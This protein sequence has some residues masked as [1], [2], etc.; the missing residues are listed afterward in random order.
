MLRT[1]SR[2]SEVIRVLA[3]MCPAMATARSL[4]PPELDT[5]TC[6]RAYTRCAGVHVSGV[7]DTVSESLRI[8]HTQTN[9]TYWEDGAYTTRLHVW[10]DPSG[11]ID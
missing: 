3:R 8:V 5:T 4:L 7:D 1:V 11:E 6:V 10:L 9:P 2:L